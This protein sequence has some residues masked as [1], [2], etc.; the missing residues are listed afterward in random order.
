MKNIENAG[1]GYKNIIISVIS[2]LITTVV[3]IIVFAAVMYFLELDK[4]Y[5]VVLATVSVAFGDFVTA[6]ILAK[7]NKVKGFITGLAV[8]SAVFV[9]ILL[10]SLIADKGAVSINTL[11]HFII[12]VLSGII[13]GVM[14]VNKADSTKYIK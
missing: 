6:Y 2:G 7:K 11:F 13:G 12:F 3:F 10:I 8:G 1:K 4:S 5:S 9:I 14:G